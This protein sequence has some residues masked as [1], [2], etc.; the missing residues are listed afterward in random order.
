[1]LSIL[2]LPTE[3]GKHQMI[4]RRYGDCLTCGHAVD[5][6]VFIILTAFVSDCSGQ[7]SSKMISS[8]EHSSQD[9]ICSL[10]EQPE[11]GDPSSLRERR[12]TLRLRQT[13]LERQGSP[14]EGSTSGVFVPKRLQLAS[15]GQGARATKESEVQCDP[16]AEQGGAPSLTGASP[17]NQLGAKK[18]TS[19]RPLAVYANGRLTIDADNASLENVIKAVQNLTGLVVEFPAEKMD[20]RIFDHVGPVSVREA[21]TELL[22]GS[23]FNYIFRTAPGDPENVKRLVLSAQARL[24]GETPPQAG[25][26]AS[27]PQPARQAYGGAGFEDV[28]AE[29]DEAALPVPP[30]PSKPTIDPSTVPGIPPGFNLQQAAAQANKTPAQLLDEMQKHQLELLDAQAP[31]Q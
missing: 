3:T 9:P 10:T 27:N 13:N 24:P 17:N 8:P 20:R 11:P 12:D 15:L 1:M 2:E 7:A 26:G 6:C 4:I 21:L 18:S 29:G 25:N 22:Y 23:G 5:L 30:P 28:S 14:A 16:D 31:P 19:I